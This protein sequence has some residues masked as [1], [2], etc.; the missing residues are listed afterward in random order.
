M[1]EI[2]IY[3]TLN[4]ATPDGVIAKAEQI[5]DSTQGKKQSEINADYKKRIETLETGGGTGS[6]TTDYNDLTNKPQ[7]NGH[8]LSGNKSPEDL[9]LQ[10]AGDYALKSEI[11]DTSNFATKNELN[12]V[13]PTIGENGNWFLGEEDTGVQAQGKDGKDGKDGAQGNSGVSGTTDNIV[14][15]NDLNGG[16]S[17]PENIKVL[18]AEQGKVLNNKL[19]ELS[20]KKLDKISTSENKLRD[21]SESFCFCDKSGN[22]IAIINPEGLQAIKFLDKD[23]NEIVPISIDVI[24]SLI[25]GKAINEDGVSNL[26]NLRFKNTGILSGTDDGFY[27]TDRNGNVI[28]K[29]TSEGLQAIKFLDKDENEIGGVDIEGEDNT[30]PI[31]YANKL[32]STLIRPHSLCGKYIY[33]I[34]DSHTYA[35]M[36]HLAELTGAIYNGDLHKHILSENEKLPGVHTM[37]TQ[38]HAIVEWYKKGNPVDALFIENVHHLFN[39][40]IDVDPYENNILYDG[41]SFSTYTEMQEEMK[42]TYFDNLLA[43]NEPTPNGAFVVSVLTSVQRVQFAFSSGDVCTGGSVSLKLEDESGETYSASITVD[44]GMTL[45]DVVNKINTI[46]FDEFFHVWGNP[47]HHQDL[48]GKTYI[49][50]QYT[51]NT[52]SDN[53]NRK[54]S[55][56]TDDTTANVIISSNTD[57]STSF[58]YHYC[59]WSRDISKWSDKSC[60]HYQ[61][62]GAFTTDSMKYYKAMVEILQKNIPNCKLY[63]WTCPNIAVDWNTNTTTDDKIS[64]TYE[65]GSINIAKWKSSVK[66]SQDIKRAK[67]LNELAEYYNIPCLNVQDLWGVNVLNG[68]YFYKNNDVHLSGGEYSGYDRVAEL[69][70]SLTR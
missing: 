64:M 16:E 57:A 38:A 28:V 51:G 46:Q 19:T 49:D 9:G 13:K 8:E 26:I 66:G 44:S 53:K 34:G 12:G 37:C 2:N 63:I 70:A 24:E 52:D 5:K 4:N 42:G 30:V 25:G 11:P 7:I 31:L 29:I 1:T 17:T 3:G 69:L 18:A 50:F 56:N 60:W 33:S 22:V 21:S 32:K 20:N 35:Y 14:V 61:S 59:F 67:G 39:D 40:G 43:E 41:G 23:G 15:V 27:F 55:I 68:K 62:G 54:I 58:D 45:A 48:G 6:G 65:D 10:Q 47:N 36:K